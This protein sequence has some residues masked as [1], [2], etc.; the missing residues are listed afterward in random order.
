MARRPL[1]MAR[2]TLSTPRVCGGGSAAMSGLSAL[3]EYYAG[4][5][6]SAQCGADAS[7]GAPSRPPW[8]KLPRKRD[9]GARPG[10]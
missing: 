1:R 9:S 10:E 2:S 8:F 4:V 3:E 6:A 7:K 5:R